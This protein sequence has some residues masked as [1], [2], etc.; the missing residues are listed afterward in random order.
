M[1]RRAI[2]A[3]GVAAVGLALAGSA[4]AVRGAETKLFAQ[5][6]PEATIML[7]DGQGNRVTQLDP[8]AYE[9][10][11]KDLSDEHNFH[12]TGPGVNQLTEVSFVG[13]TTWHVSFQDGNYRYVCDP[14]AT[15]MRGTF[16]VGTPQATPPPATATPSA[17]VGARLLLTVGP[18]PVI[19]LKTTAGKPVKVLRAGSYTFVARDRSAT[20]NAH[21]LGAGVNRSTGVAFTGSRTWKLTVRKGTLVFR[22]DPH[23][24]TL[25][26]SVQIVA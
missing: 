16:T 25:R 12:L 3:V 26:G 21:L 18:T 20:H 6:G 10:E 15:S 19:S 23:R 5:V 1:G 24:T 13:E 8:G 2:A 22:C 7:R 14:H 4:P 9:I 11:V 17:P